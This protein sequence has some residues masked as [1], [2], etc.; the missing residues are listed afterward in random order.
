MSKLI[1]SLEILS[2]RKLNGDEAQRMLALQKLYGVDDEDPVMFGFSMLAS[3]QLATESGPGAIRAAVDQTIELHRT[4]LRDQAVLISKELI[5]EI[6][7]RILAAVENQKPPTWYAL[8]AA[9]GG[10]VG[11]TLVML[12]VFKL[13]FL[14]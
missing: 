11:F 1:E 5:V 4:N 3:S 6:T 12:F 14:R 8:A 9:F 10:G 2:G 13:Y 7:K